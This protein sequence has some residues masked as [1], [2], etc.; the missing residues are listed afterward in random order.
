VNYCLDY[1][2]KLPDFVS[3]SSNPA[4]AK[5][6]EELLKGFGEWKSK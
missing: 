3:H 5:N 2:L 6:I 4:G 1:D